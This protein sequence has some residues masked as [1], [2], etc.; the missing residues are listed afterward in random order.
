M[1]W[2]LNE[3]AA[4][5]QKFIGL[6]VTDGTAPP[7]GRPVAVRF[8][9]PETELADAT[10]PMIILEHAAISKADDREHRGLTILPYVPED[11]PIKSFTVYDEQGTQV[12]WNPQAEAD[13]TLSPIRV[14]DYPVPYNIDYDVT[15]YARK[16]SH[17][18]E[19]VVALAAIDR[20]PSRFGYVQVAADGTTRTLDLLGG[21]EIVAEKDR[22][23]KRIFRAVYSV[24]V[25]SELDLYG[26]TVAT[27]WPQ[28]VEVTLKPHS[29]P[30]G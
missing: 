11:E 4:L 17:I 15:V 27:N 16:Q 23:G 26:H 28:T 25:V 22:D 10:F 13:V 6:T 1:T 3:D 30:L 14:P 21:P 20:I 19:L 24:R 5:K 2:L 12:I 18:M 8:R 9:L 7:L 29:E